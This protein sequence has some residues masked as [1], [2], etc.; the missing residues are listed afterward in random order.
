MG[1][2]DWA[3][4]RAALT[5][6]GID[7]RQLDVGPDQF[8]GARR[9]VGTTSE[10]ADIAVKVYGRD[11]TDSQVMAKVWHA[12]MYRGSHRVTFTRVQSVQQEAL[13]TI[14]A[15][16]AEVSVPDVTAAAA[17]TGEVAL[18]ATTRSGTLLADVDDATLLDQDALASL[19]QQV[20]AMH[21]AGVTHGN[22]G[23]DSVRV[24]ETGFGIE[25]FENGSTVY[26]ESE[27]CLDV[28]T[29]LF[30]TAVKVGPEAAVTAAAAGLGRESR[31]TSG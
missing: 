2:P 20:E 6:M 21:V 11:A 8:W 4:V 23:V 24:G 10:G 7:T 31:G 22:L 3:A 13:V 27:A 25:D 14:M 28:V 29:L 12:M 18:L 16:R 1:Y 17:P 30:D 26:Q 15:G 9:F 5:R 19:W